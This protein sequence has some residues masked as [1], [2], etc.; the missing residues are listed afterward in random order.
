M[1]KTIQIL[2]TAVNPQLP[3]LA[4]PAIN[5]PCPKGHDALNPKIFFLNP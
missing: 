4:T 5:P 2:N 3:G 1:P